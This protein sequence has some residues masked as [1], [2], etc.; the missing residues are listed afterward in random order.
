MYIGE[1]AAKAGVSVQ[2]VRFYERRGLMRKAARSPVGYRRYGKDDLEILKAIAQCQSLGFTLAETRRLL[3][4]FWVPDP[5]TG[6]PRYEANDTACLVDA[7]EIGREK[8]ATLDREIE[9]L[10]RCRAA[11]AATLTRVRKTIKQ[12]QRERA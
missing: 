12:R 9:R 6:R 11:L 5:K 7:A 3:A 8:L 4:L 2:A 10:T 1:I